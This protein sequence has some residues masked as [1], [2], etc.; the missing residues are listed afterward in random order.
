MRLLIQRVS[1]ASVTI[2]GGEI[3]SIGRGVVV[4]AAVGPEDT[5]KDAER[6]ADKTARLRIF[7]NDDGKFDKSLLDVS[8]EAL[9]VSQFTLYGDASKGRRPD[10]TGAAAPEKAEPLYRLYASAL[11]GLGV[12]VKTGEFGASMSVEIV[13]DGPVTIWLEGGADKG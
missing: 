4:F 8:G 10:F 3:R 1:K 5:E 13:N 6:F 12:A 2:N 11:A 9:V 7:P